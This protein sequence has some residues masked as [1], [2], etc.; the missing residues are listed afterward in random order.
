MNKS[1]GEKIKFLRLEKSIN[2][3]MLAK[4]LNVTKAT[5]S[6][7]ETHMQEPDFD[8]LVKIAKYFQVTTDFL[9]GLED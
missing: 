9:L 6:H 2:Q 1:F 8:T 4:E 5:V 3:T 7:W